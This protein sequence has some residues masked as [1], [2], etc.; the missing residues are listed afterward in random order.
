MSLPET[1]GGIEARAKRGGLEVRW[2][3]A[4][5]PELDQALKTLP[6]LP[7]CPHDLYRE[8][9][10][11]TRAQKKHAL[12]LENGQP[13]ALVSLRSCARHWEPVAMNMFVVEWAKAQGF[14]LLDL[15]SGVYKRDWGQLAAS[16]SAP[17][18]ARA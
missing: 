6:P 11:P 5:T 13:V 10:K 3:N 8:L 16:A 15:G 2:S 4:R 9:L 17:F 14:S 18:S 1:M 12:V 7:D